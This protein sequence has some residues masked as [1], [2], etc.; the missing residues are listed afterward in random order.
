MIRLIQQFEFGC[1]HCSVKE[2]GEDRPPGWTN[3]RT[4]GHG[5]TGYTQDELL[6]DKCTAKEKQKGKKSP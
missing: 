4:H 3:I 2:R 6:C 1:D 5:M